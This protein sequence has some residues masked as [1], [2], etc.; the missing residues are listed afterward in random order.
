MSIKI[1]INGFGRIGRLAFRRIAEEKGME[2]VA[3]N[4]LTDAENLAYLLKYDTAHGRFHVDD[5]SV[6]ADGTAIVFKGKEIPVYAQP[7][8]TLLNWT[9]HGVDIVLECTGRFRGKEDASVHL[10]EGVKAVIISAPADKETPMFVYGVNTDKLTKEMTVISGAS[11]TTNALA[12]VVKVLDDNFGI[13]HGLMTTVHAYTNDQ[14]ILDLPKKKAARRGRAGAMNIVPTSTGAAKAIGQV[15]PH[16]N[17]KLDGGA[18]RVPVLDGSM[19]DLTVILK[20]KVTAEE[21]NAAMKKAAAGKMKAILGYTEDEVVS[22]DIIG[23]THGGLFD[24]TLTK[25]MEVDGAQL[26]KVMFWYDNEYGYT[27]QY[28]RLAAEVAKVHG[29]K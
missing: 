1:A 18:L 4:D 12:P 7:D 28:I 3:I 13:V 15:I 14:T 20:K 22:N 2:V 11:C 16:L 9:K 10:H 23:D 25:V 6:T 24:A 19:V 21:I 27:C 29:L 8:P 26:V 5:I 17:K